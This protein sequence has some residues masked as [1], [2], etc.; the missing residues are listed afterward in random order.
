MRENFGLDAVR[1]FSEITPDRDLQEK[2]EEVFGSVDLIDAWVGGLAE[3][4]VRGAMVGETVQAVLAEQF[5]RLRDGDRF[6]Y[7]NHLSREL[8]RLV[9][10]QTLSKIIQRNT[11]ISREIPEDL[12]KVGKLVPGAPVGMGQPGGS[13]R[14]PMGP[15]RRR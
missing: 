5:R 13:G 1:D 3:P 2:L 11:E 6:W 15:P 8:Q 9:E 4:P 14:P 7:Q 10:G 12:W